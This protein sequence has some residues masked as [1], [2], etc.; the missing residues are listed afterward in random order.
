MKYL[1]TIQKTE[2]MMDSV[3]TV[4]Y[5]NKILFI[6]KEQCV[7]KWTIQ[8]PDHSKIEQRLTI[9]NPELSR[10]QIPTVYT[11]ILNSVSQPG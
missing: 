3:Q 10:F 5:K 9:Q 7:G 6:L 11:F 2:K 1:P 4:L 8:I